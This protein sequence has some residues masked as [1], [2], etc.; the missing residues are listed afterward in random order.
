M[1]LR[2]LFLGLVILG[3]MLL[4]MSNSAD[5]QAAAESVLLNGHVG[6]AGAKAGTAMGNSLSRATSGLAGQ[7][8]NVPHSNVAVHRTPRT[9]PA[10]RN[11]G[12]SSTTVTPAP[13]PSTSGGSMITSIQG[14]HLTRPSSAATTPH[15][16]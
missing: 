8:Q 2:F 10:S 9:A 4:G 12:A 14:G 3:V 5:A 11:S 7:I 13:A 16:N 1:R 6:V 15:H